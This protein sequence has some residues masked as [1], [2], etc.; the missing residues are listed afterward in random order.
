MIVENDMATTGHI[1]VKKY[2]DPSITQRGINQL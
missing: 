2:P 1:A